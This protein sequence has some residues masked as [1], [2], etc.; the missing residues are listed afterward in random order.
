[1]YILVKHYII[2]E[3]NTD[4]VVELLL[5]YYKTDVFVHGKTEQLEK[6]LKEMGETEILNQFEKGT[7]AR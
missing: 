7:F 2:D 3:K 6:A 4:K 5:D 1:M